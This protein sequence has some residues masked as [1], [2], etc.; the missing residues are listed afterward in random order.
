MGH[1]FF[2]YVIVTNHLYSKG[3]YFCLLGYFWHSP[4]GDTYT[5]ANTHTHTHAISQPK[6]RYLADVN[7]ETFVN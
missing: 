1:E 6:V 2:V 4:S 7:V 5:H 3:M